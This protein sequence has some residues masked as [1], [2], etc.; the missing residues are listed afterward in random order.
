LPIGPFRAALCALALVQVLSLCPARAEAANEPPKPPPTPELAA[1]IGQTGAEPL[2]VVAISDVRKLGDLLAATGLGRL[3]ND[4]RYVDGRATIHRLLQDFLGAEAAPLWES[5]R[6]HC[7]GPVALVVSAADVADGEKFGGLRYQLLVAAPHKGALDALANVW[8]KEEARTGA[9]AKIE[10]KAI[11]IETLHELKPPEWAKRY[12]DLPGNVRVDVH[13]QAALKQLKDWIE[14]HGGRLLAEE[15]AK[16][17]TLLGLASLDLQDIEWDA[18]ADEQDFVERLKLTLMPEAKGAFA[19]LGQVLCASAR[20]FDRLMGAMSGDID[21]SVLAQLDFKAMGDDFAPLMRHAERYVRGKGWTNKFGQ[22][23]DALNPERYKFIETLSDGMF[24][25]GTRVTETASTRQVLT[26]SLTNRDVEAVRTSLAESLSKLGGEFQ[27]SAQATAIG[28]NRPL[29]AKFKGRGSF[30]S[31]T[32]G[33]SSGWAW[34]CGTASSYGD[35]AEAFSKGNTLAATKAEVHYPPGLAPTLA[36]A[37]RFSANLPRVFTLMYAAWV[38]ADQGPS[39]GDWKIPAELLPAP[40]AFKG[41]VTPLNIEIAREASELQ[42]H[43]RGPLP[44][45]TLLLTSFFADLALMIERER[46]DGEL[47]KKLEGLDD[48]ARKPE[49]PKPEKKDTPQPVEPKSETPAPEK[50]ASTPTPAPD[51]KDKAPTIE[52]EEGGN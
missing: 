40:A 39:I 4:A 13:P 36:P 26:F 10:F 21:M 15:R 38:L 3:Y 11:E 16:Y 35:M 27:T 1:L 22:T 42:V 29:A 46:G 47:K 6:P 25:L 37:F 52:L 5:V 20:P 43:A 49:A 8:P 31:P 44:G 45:S 48:P 17:D 2:A 30:A 12:A 28:E 19:H 50:P 32:I 9:L 18:K 24:G 51:K 34:L 33:L 14:K 7:A 23:Q 41:K